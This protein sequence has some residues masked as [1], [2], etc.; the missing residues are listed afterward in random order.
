MQLGVVRYLA[1]CFPFLAD[2]LQPLFQHTAPDLQHMPNTQ[3]VSSPRV[4]TCGL[5][6]DLDPAVLCCR[7]CVAADALPL[8]CCCC[9]VAAAV[10]PL[11]RCV[12]AAVLLLLRPCRI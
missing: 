5:H 8:L 12:A 1:A 9:C 10:L 4:S 6:H 3:L 11:L 2:P 7:C